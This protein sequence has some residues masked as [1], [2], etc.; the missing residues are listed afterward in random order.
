MLKPLSM[1]T[2]QVLLNT[3][4]WTRGEG[5]ET[6][7][8]EVT[9]AMGIGVHCLLI[10]EVPGAQMGDNEVRNACVFE[11]FF[12]DDTTPKILLKMGLYNE[13]AMNLAGGT[14]RLAGLIKTCQTIAAGGDERKPVDLASFQAPAAVQVD[15]STASSAFAAASSTLPRFSRELFG[16][17]ASSSTSGSST[18]H[19]STSNVYPSAGVE[20]N[21]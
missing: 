4:T 16:I 15:N 21:I 20:L 18:S 3:I 7:V 19:S 5:S 12:D 2:F 17:P 13:I 9:N 10:H 8:E 1:A 14:L 6:F 11:R